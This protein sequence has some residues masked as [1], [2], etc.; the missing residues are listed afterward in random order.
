MRNSNLNF[1]STENQHEILMKFGKCL[2]HNW[3][4]NYVQY[5]FT[6]L[7]PKFDWLVTFTMVG[8][9]ANI[10]GI[11]VPTVIK[12]AQNVSKRPILKLL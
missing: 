4:R 9:F 10:W 5:G 2:Y 3:S 8:Q 6:V 7:L 11:M 1:V 12:F